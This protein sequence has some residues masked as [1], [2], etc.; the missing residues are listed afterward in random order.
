[1][2]LRIYYSSDK[3]PKVCLAEMTADAP[4]D[5]PSIGCGHA[6]SHEFQ[7]LFA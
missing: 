6:Y 5:H 4:V 7:I 2:S 1:M 3:D